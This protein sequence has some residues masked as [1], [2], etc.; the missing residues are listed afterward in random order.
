MSKPP[1]SSVDNSLVCQSPSLDPVAALG[2][3]DNTV[4]DG[5]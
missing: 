5:V 1:P 3:F 2:T 4:L